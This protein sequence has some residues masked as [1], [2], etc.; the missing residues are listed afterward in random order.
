[1]TKLTRLAKGTFAL[2]YAGAISASEK[3]ETLYVLI[4]NDIDTDS[5][6]RAKINSLIAPMTLCPILT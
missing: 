4:V 2:F 5:R 3:E 1:M 6:I